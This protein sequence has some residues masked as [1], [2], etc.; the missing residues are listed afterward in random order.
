MYSNFINKIVYKLALKRIDKVGYIGGNQKIF[1]RFFKVKRNKLYRISTYLP[2]IASLEKKNAFS[3]LLEKEL[4]KIKNNYKK[5]VVASGYPTKIYRH[6]WVLDF[7]EHVDLAEGSALILCLYGMDSENRLDMLLSRA[8]KMPNVFVYKYLSP[9]QFQT[10]LSTADIYVR[11]TKVDSFG[12]AVAEA[13]CLGL[14]VVASDACERA[15]GAFIFDRNDKHSFITTLSDIIN[16]NKLF[17]EEYI[18]QNLNDVS[19]FLGLS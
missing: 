5:I 4:N 11:P 9:D 13:L 19:K 16:D 1:F 8:D 14:K 2:F 3:K 18:D 15:K 10:V 7:F 17:V 6:D 12:V